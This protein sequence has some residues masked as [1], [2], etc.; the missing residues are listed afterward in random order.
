MIGALAVVVADGVA[1]VVEE[2]TV[3]EGAIVVDGVGNGNGTLARHSV[4][5]ADKVIKVI[6]PE[7]FIFN[8]CQVSFTI[9]CTVEL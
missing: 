7:C 4:I 2:P 5:T 9:D 6:T 1:L 8:S 3:V